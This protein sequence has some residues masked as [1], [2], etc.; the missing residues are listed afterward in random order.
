VRLRLSNSRHRR[1]LTRH[2]LSFFVERAVSPRICAGLYVE[3][4]F[5]DGLHESTGMLAGTTWIDDNVRP[6]EFD[7]EIDGDLDG[8][9][10]LRA[11]SHEAAHIRQYAHGHLV[12]MVRK[13]DKVKWRGELYDR[14][15][16]RN[17]HRHLAPWERE[18]NRL[19]CSLVWE[20]LRTH[21]RWW[22]E[23]RVLG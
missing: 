15:L 4:R 14:E 7:V 12:D 22:D 11:L 9:S 1:A 13:H 2:S 17:E 5:I 20:Y 3:V 16:M 8:K 19:E 10:L 18:A 23:S 21:G 6:R